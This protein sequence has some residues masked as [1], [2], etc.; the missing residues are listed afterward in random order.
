MISASSLRDRGEI[1]PEAGIGGDQHFDV[2]AEFPRQYRPLYAAARECR[3]WR[4]RRARLSHLA[5]ACPHALIVARSDRG[6]DELHSFNSVS[7]RRQ[8][9]AGRV[10]GAD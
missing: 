1:E 6:S 8:V 3:D 4:V 9:R 5:E 2:A 7:K 10:S